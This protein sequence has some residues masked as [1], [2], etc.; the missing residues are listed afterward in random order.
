MEHLY[1]IKQASEY[2]YQLLNS[3]ILQSLLTNNSPLLRLLQ[4]FCIYG[5][6]W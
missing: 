4:L 5:Y 1:I 3:F 6:L 2:F